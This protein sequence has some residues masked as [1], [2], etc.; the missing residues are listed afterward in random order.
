MKLAEALALRSNTQK[1]F[2]NLKQR[3]LR[4]AKVQE[5]DEPAESP[6]ELQGQMDE[7]LTQLQR[8]IQNINATNAVTRIDNVGTLSDA[9]AQRDILRMRQLAYQDLAT[10]AAITPPR[11]TRSEVRFVSAVNVAGAQRLADAAA[12]ELRELDARIQEANWLTELI[13]DR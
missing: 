1:R 10:T 7:L 12:Q 8:L 5:G 13:E 9:V 6:A 11:A 2:E 4:V 3:L